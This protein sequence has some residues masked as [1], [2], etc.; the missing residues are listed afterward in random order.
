MR[1]NTILLLGAFWGAL[2]PATLALAHSE[3]GPGSHWVDGCTAS[4]DIIHT[5]WEVELDT[6][7]D[8]NLD[9][10]LDISLT[11]SGPM[12]ITRSAALDDSITFPG[13]RPTDSH[14][15]VIDTEVV[16]LSLT[17]GAFVNVLAGDGSG[18]GGVLGPSYGAMAEQTSDSTLANSFVNIF[19][20]A[21]AFGVLIYNHAPIS[22]TAVDDGV[23]SD[24]AYDSGPICVGGFTLPVGGGQL[25][26]L[27]KLA[28]TVQPPPVPI[29]AQSD[30]PCVNGQ[31]GPFS[32]H[33]IHLEALI[34]LDEF[35]EGPA[36]DVWGWT[37]PST[38]RDYAILGLAGGTAFLDLGDPKNPIY[39]GLLPTNTDPS[40]WRDM[41]VAGDYAFI[42]S[43]DPAHGMQI[44]DLT[45][46]STV[47]SPPVTFAE[48][49]HFSG[50]GAAHNIAI[51]EDTEVAYVVGADTCAGSLHMID[52]SNPLT[53]VSLGCSTAGGY[54]H[55]TQCVVYSG[56]D[57]AHVGKEVCFNSTL[58]SLTVMDVTT[59]ATPL[60]LSNT[61]YTGSSYAHQGWLTED[62]EYF[63]MG[64]E[65]DEITF[66]HNTRTYIWDVSDLDAPVLVGD[67]TG[68]LA[69]GDH[70]LYVRG[71]QVFEA[72]W[73]SG[74]R[75]LKIGD[76][77]TPPGLSEI[78]F[79][80][81]YPSHDLAGLIGAWSVYPFFDSGTILVSDMVNGLF[82]LTQE[83]AERPVLVPGL[84]PPS[85]I[86]LLGLLG[87]AGLAAVRVRRRGSK[88]R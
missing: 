35:D 85:V 72:N 74:L 48:D 66:F 6:V 37:D 16:S 36:N 81:T 4:V 71:E 56:P 82:V 5:L 53:P 39:L 54:A 42:V 13:T 32:C 38:D 18:N 41:K 87:G 12:R 64:D 14:L 7:F 24:E 21:K 65:L 9:C 28:Y 33:G 60:M 50:F 88:N 29:A 30:V 27:L 68:L 8:G 51:N 25:G 77:S 58:S 44:F 45:Q 55:D 76:L 61:A 26:N 15:D 20:E 23:P 46:L 59:K 10:L 49:A 84:R 79:F 22:M 75:I 2:S 11:V 40:P 43:E 70:N 57:T 1:F 83:P 78:A 67:Y 52:I 86:A 62:H 80:D 47:V 63:V 34:P 69:A 73:T 17:D 19:A 3:C 31:A